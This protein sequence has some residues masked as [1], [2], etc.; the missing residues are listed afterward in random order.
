MGE[1]LLWVANQTG[2][3][4]YDTTGNAKLN[5]NFNFIKEILQL[6]LEFPHSFY[7]LQFKFN[8]QRSSIL[9]GR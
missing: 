3:R 4:V 8:Y 1:A 2:L 7:S 5:D 9:C 6:F